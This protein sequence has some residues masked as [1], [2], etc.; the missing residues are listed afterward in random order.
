ML[1]TLESWNTRRRVKRIK[2]IDDRSLS[3]QTKG[4]KHEPCLKAVPVEHSSKRKPDLS[5]W[6]EALRS[7]ECLCMVPPLLVLL[8]LV[9]HW[10]KDTENK[11][12]AVSIK[13]TSVSQYPSAPLAPRY[14]QHAWLMARV[15]LASFTWHQDFLSK[16]AFEQKRQ[17]S[18]HACQ[19]L[20]PW[21]LQSETLSVEWSWQLM[22]DMLN[23]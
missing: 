4:I 13:N 7:P 14:T 17:N 15:P 5:A 1:A 20:S 21:H 23:C 6:K 19:S 8:Q 12:T 11:R 22:C 3:C 9:L 16:P 2:A 18:P 10:D